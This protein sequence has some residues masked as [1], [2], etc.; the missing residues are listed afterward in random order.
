MIIPPPLTINHAVCEKIGPREPHFS[1][2]REKRA[3]EESV[4]WPRIRE[5]EAPAAGRCLSLVSSP[6]EAPGE[7]LRP[8]EPAVFL[9]P[10]CLQLLQEKFKSARDIFNENRF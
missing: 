2:S 8:G 9:T 5:D 1:A 4:A 6:G 7:R 10:R 3:G